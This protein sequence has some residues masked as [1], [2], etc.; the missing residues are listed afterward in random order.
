MKSDH[1]QRALQQHTTSASKPHLQYMSAFSCITGKVIKLAAAFVSRL[2]MRSLDT[3]TRGMNCKTW[4]HLP[5]FPRNCTRKYAKM[6]EPCGSVPEVQP[7]KR[8]SNFGHHRTYEDTQGKK[9]NSW[10]CKNT[11]FCTRKTQHSNL[12][13]KKNYNSD[14]CNEKKPFLEVCTINETRFGYFFAFT[15]TK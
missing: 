8:Q 9:P 13:T 12:R 15:R 1:P 7:M 14:L 10:L 5:T 2:Q 3:K 4:N 11:H 6:D